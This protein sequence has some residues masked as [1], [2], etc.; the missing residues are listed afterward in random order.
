MRYANRVLLTLLLLCSP[1]IAAENVHQ[2][3]R[4]AFSLEQQ[5]KFDEAIASANRA[6][7][8]GEL[9]EVERGRACIMLGVSYHQIGKFN[10][11]QS[12]FE[13][14][15]RIFKND[16]DHLSDFA[17]ALNNFGGLYIDVGQFAVAVVMWKKA[18]HLRQQTGDHAASARSL[19]ALAGLSLA[20]RR[21]KKAKDYLKRASEE[22]SLASDLVDDD[23][24][25]LFENQAWL[26]LAEGHA[27]VAVVD[28]QRALE[29]CQRTRGHDHWLTG[30]EHVLRGEAYFQSGDLENAIADMREGLAILDRALSHENPKYL[31]A[32]IAFS[33]IL[34]R[35]GAHAEAEQLRASARQ[36]S[37]DFYGGQ[38]VGCTINAVGFR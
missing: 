31:A 35:D 23:F 27:S 8:S 10:E 25:F 3:L 32:E 9:S 21:T 20:Q 17:A 29:L 2:Q 28:F 30:W 37:K 5:G 18:L 15:V 24:T 26:A 38:C 4:G 19:M 6:I 22:M 14:S 16:H 1:L 34:D 33:R 12:A 7:E 11:A 36:V 13:R